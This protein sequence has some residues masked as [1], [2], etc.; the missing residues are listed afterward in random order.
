MRRRP[1]VLL[2]GPEPA[3]HSLD[4]LARLAAALAGGPDA[5]ARLLGATLAAGP[6]RYLADESDLREL[7][8]QKYLRTPPAAA[9]AAAPEELDDERRVVA[10]RLARLS[11]VDRAAVV[12]VR[13][14]GLTLAEVAGLLEISPTAL[15]RRLDGA[16]STVAADPFVLRATLEALS[17]RVP[18]PESVAAARFRAEQA[19]DRRRGRRRLLALVL[20]LVIVAAVA[21]PT[22]E[23]LRP[24][25]S[26]TAGE[27]VFGLTVE[28]SPGWTVDLHA[29]S[30]DQEFLTITTAEAGQ[31]QLHAA[32][33][34]APRDDRVEAPARSDRIWVNGK[35]AA[36]SAE[37][38]EGAGVR[39]PYGDGGQVTLVCGD[40]QDR[41][42]ILDVAR[43]VRFSAGDRLA[44]P[45]ALGR[46][47]DGFRV[48]GTGYL[49]DSP[50]ILLI[51]GPGLADAD[52]DARILV[53]VS[54]DS[55][56]LAGH[57]VVTN[58]VTLKVITLDREVRVCRAAQSPTVCAAIGRGR[59]T[60]RATEEA[61]RRVVEVMRTLRVAPDLTDRATWFDAR[62]ALPR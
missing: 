7:L 6:V 29:V 55:A 61:T 21:V 60:A 23:A 44:L 24:L 26:R 1:Q 16:E 34:S 30:A 54:A 4:D 33:P 40:R 35:P 20:G 27:W 39:W 10:E 52:V 62:E 50:A 13:L 12:L 57:T 17:W 9:A 47:P 56:E 59:P 5:A 11:P 53:T 36:Y 14:T 46:L 15:R 8:V 51:S 32:L 2:D 58:S 3:E 28:P 49:D 38:I 19:A 43:R 48:G 25:P 31:C 18:A 22:V 45:V 37:Y 41:Q 42:A